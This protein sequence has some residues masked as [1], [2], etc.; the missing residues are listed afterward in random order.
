MENRA[1]V[2][3]GRGGDKEDQQ[4]LTYIDEIDLSKLTF[5]GS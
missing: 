5:R 1:K 2:N 3:I 4:D